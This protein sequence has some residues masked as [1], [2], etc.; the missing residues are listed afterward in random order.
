MFLS[1]LGL[2]PFGQFAILKHVF[3]GKIGQR[4]IFPHP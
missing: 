2:L 3:R 4:I 1:G